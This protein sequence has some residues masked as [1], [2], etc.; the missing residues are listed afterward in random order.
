MAVDLVV[1][2][3][4]REDVVPEVHRMENPGDRVMRLESHRKAPMRRMS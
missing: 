3:D 4:A 2:L 1:V